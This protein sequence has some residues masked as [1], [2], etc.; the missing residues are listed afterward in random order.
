[1]ISIN[2]WFIRKKRC[3]A[4]SAGRFAGGEQMI[5]R[6]MESFIVIADCGS[7][8]KASE[9]LFISSTAAMKQMNQLEARL[10]ITLIKRTNHGTEL[11]SAGE[12]VY[13]YAREMKKI[14]EK[15]LEEAKDAGTSRSVIRVG[16]S[17]LN[18]CKPF[19]DLWEHMNSRFPEYRMQIVPFDDAHEDILNVINRVGSEID[20][21]VGVCDSEKWLSRCSFMKLGE[22]R[23]CIAVPRGHRLADRHLLSP[24]DL[25]GEIMIMVREGDSPV[26]DRIR[27]DLTEHWPEIRIEDASNF[28]DIS[29]YNHCVEENILMLNNECWSDVH[30]GLVTIPVDWDYT[31]PYG[32]IYSGD[33]EE[34]IAD[35]LEKIED[36]MS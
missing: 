26:N 11:T 14:Q 25:R 8:N 2:Y 12:I 4:C 5:S 28:Y 29:V 1:M 18:P 16:T 24:D 30:P 9:K 6:E 33:P 7:F 36:E 20:L 34:Q 35:L 32:I 23:K 10:G 13:R 15:A 27:K 31:I 22:Y 19:M 21:I 3:D 17:I